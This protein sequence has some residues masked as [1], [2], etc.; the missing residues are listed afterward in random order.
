M[1]EQLTLFD[2]HPDRV[3]VVLSYGMGVDSTALLLRWLHEPGSRDFAMEDLVALTAMT[4]D[5][6]QD[7][8]ALVTAHILHRLREHR[9]RFVQVARTGALEGEGI[10]VLDDSRAPTQLHMRG[11]YRLSDELLSVGTVPQVA[12][13]QRRCTHHFKGFPLSTW[14]RRE[15]GDAPIRRAIG[16]NADE[17]ERADRAEGYSTDDQPYEFPLVSWGWGRERC[18]G[19]VR[20]VVG[21]TWR[22]SCCVFCPF[23]RGKPDVLERYRA[24]PCEAA[25]ALFLEYV[26][27]CMNPAMTLYA[28]KSLRSVLERDG[29]RDALRLLEERLDSTPWAIYRVRRIVWAKGRADRRTEKIIDGTRAEV[30]AELTSRGAGAEH[31]IVRGRVRERGQT[32]PTVEEMV[33]AAPAVVADKSRP[34][35]EDNWRRLTAA[36]LWDAGGR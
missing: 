27:L 33:V 25:E 18:V 9:V 10:T 14:T 30:T 13:G 8:D 26:S 35:F 16:Y 32:Y 36:G 11:P 20:E 23:T 21:E 6:F 19:Y 7:T 4:G 28:S 12:S 1:P 29:N 2:S 22:K 17:Q 3:P 31:G 15:Y 34:G 5:E 24:S